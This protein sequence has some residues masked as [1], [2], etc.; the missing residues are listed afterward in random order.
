[1]DRE[2]AILNI[3]SDHAILA[4][5]LPLNPLLKVMVECFGGVY[6]EEREK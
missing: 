5:P 6:I 2:A 4:I 1:M 3:L